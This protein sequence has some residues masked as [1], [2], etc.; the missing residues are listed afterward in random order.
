MLFTLWRKCDKLQQE[1]GEW[2]QKLT[3]M[4]SKQW[5]CEQ[6]AWACEDE[7]ASLKIM[8]RVSF[9]VWNCCCFL[10]VSSSSAKMF[11]NIT[12]PN[13]CCSPDAGGFKKK[14]D[15]KLVLKLV[16]QLVSVSVRW[17]PAVYGCSRVSKLAQDSN[18][19]KHPTQ[20]EPNSQCFKMHQ[21]EM[22][23]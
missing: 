1:R 22:S 8:L 15:D 6:S 18:V 23:G 13:S 19:Q 10:Q 3:F 11:W 16:F 20:H 7:A 12:A 17:S 14:K 9:T 4:Q 2:E 5:R 21:L